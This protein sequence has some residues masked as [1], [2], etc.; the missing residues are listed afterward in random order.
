MPIS[1]GEA[2]AQ[3]VGS[4]KSA[5]LKDCGN[6][7]TCNWTLEFLQD[8]SFRWNHDGVIDSGQYYC[9]EG[10]VYVDRDTFPIDKSH[11]PE[12]R[13]STFNAVTKT[14]LWGEDHYHRNPSTY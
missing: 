9:H 1:K 10:T 13:T 5:E 12:N 8:G 11:Y 3:L 14:I 7:T 4:Y 2:C 6:N